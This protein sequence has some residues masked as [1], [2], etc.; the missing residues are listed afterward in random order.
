M[1]EMDDAT[2]EVFLVR[3]K[4]KTSHYIINRLMAEMY[5]LI[6]YI[7]LTINLR[8]Y[9]KFCLANLKSAGAT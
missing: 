4:S 5:Q 8:S 7:S 9:L 6:R 2:F 1:Y 3:N